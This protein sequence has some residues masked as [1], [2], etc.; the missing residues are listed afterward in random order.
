M[1]RSIYLHK[2]SQ[3][4]DVH[5]SYIM[6]EAAKESDTIFHRLAN[7]AMETILELSDDVLIH[8]VSKTKNE[9]TKKLVND[10]LNRN[11]LSLI[12]EFNK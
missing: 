4:A 6:N 7:P 3:G 10:Y 9:K 11:I 5:L 12:H 1:L 8:E 2:I